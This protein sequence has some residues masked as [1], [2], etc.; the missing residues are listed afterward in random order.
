MEPERKIEKLLRAYARKRRAKAGEMQSMH[1]A[2]RRLLQGE[3]ARLKPKLDDE[4]SSLSLLQ[5]FKQRWV[6]LFAFVLVI[7]L[8]TTLFMPTLSATK[9]KAQSVNAMANLK[10]IGAAA[11]LAA[12]DKNGRL[13]ASLDVLTNGYVAQ[14]IL[15]DPASGKHFIYIAGGQNLDDLESNTV[16]AY[17][18]DDNNDRAVLF[19]DGRVEYENRTRFSEITNQQELQYALRENS[20]RMLKESPMERMAPPG[21]YRPASFG[22]AGGSTPPAAKVTPDESGAASSGKINT[23]G[24][25]LGGSAGKGELEMPPAA[26][27]PASLSV[28]SSTFANRQPEAQVY[29][30]QT[31]TV[32]PPPAETAT[33]QPFMD[34]AA[35]N[36]ST[37]SQSGAASSQNY[38]KNTATQVHSVPVLA[39]FQ[40]LQNG[41][42]IRILDRDNSV[43]E[44]SFQQGYGAAQNAPAAKDQII[45]TNGITS[46]MAQNY[47]FQ[48]EGMNRTLRK[49]VLFSGN[50]QINSS[51]TANA[52]QNSSAVANN[53][54]QNQFVPDLS[55]G[56]LLLNSRITGVAV[57]DQT[58]QI[59][60]NATPVQQ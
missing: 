45:E 25:G 21:G 55:Q 52:Q 41:N 44:G 40:L 60:I 17:S 30:N 28:E 20:T 26:P 34:E 18:P 32:E 50:M 6:F 27:A 9:H 37:A 54:T 48:V 12:E 22:G 4:E 56:G 13:P 1:P 3:V 14:R 58:N 46:Q 31:V 23:V 24:G 49:K 2:T 19:A 7:F 39:S 57:I 16:L 29:S 38:F 43:Y 11:E 15:T 53:T 47:S 33:V 51:Q 59:P 35:K 10:Q 36:N 8:G 5:F 42:A